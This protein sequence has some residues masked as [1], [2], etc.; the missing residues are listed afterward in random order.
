MIRGGNGS[1]DALG[2]RPTRPR[3]PRASRKCRADFLAELMRLRSI[4]AQSH[5]LAREAVRLSDRESTE[6][7]HELHDGKSALPSSST[8]G[9]TDTGL[10]S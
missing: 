6:L 3:P 5:D 4:A 8:A 7:L 1:W 9:A 2:G 10:P